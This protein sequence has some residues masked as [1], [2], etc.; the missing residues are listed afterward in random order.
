MKALFILITLL[1]PVFVF[2]HPG[3]TA[4]DGCHYCRT[5]CSK[6]GEV[7]GARHCHGGGSLPKPSYKAPVKQIT[8]NVKNREVPGAIPAVKVAETKDSN[9]GS[10]VGGAVTIS[11]ILIGIGVGLHN[12]YK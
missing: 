9:E 7:Q 5:N 8:P 4:S 3:N 2:A 1:T 11:A 6:W 10:F 12:K